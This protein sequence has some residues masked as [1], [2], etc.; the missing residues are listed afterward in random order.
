M[1]CANPF[2]TGLL[3]LLLSAGA[4]AWEGRQ[5][6]L[7]N[8]PFE[9]STGMKSAPPESSPL[10][11]RGVVAE[12]G[13]YLF[14]LYDVAAHRSTWMRLN[15]AADA[16]AVT[17]YDEKRDTVTI[18]YRGRNYALPMKQARI[19]STAAPPPYFSPEAKLTDADKAMF[20]KR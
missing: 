17:A 5:E 9:A 7:Q 18:T 2:V 3:F 19:A 15:E 10:E 8:S 4:D 16:C 6:L 12:D 1:R 13:G 14:N 11:F 20:L